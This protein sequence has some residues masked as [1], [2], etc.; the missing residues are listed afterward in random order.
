MFVWFGLNIRHIFLLSQFL[1]ITVIT[2]FRWFLI[3]KW[4]YILLFS[5]QGSYFAC[6]RYLLATFIS[7]LFQVLFVNTF[8]RNIF[9]FKICQIVAN[10]LFFS[11]IYNTIFDLICQ[12]F[13]I[14]SHSTMEIN[15]L[16][17]KT[18][19]FNFINSFVKTL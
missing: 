2:F 6:R 3:C 10:F 19:L 17:F 16:M 15:Y 4:L 11:L 5:F 14:F 1:E 9:T 12:H 13:L 18:N 8:F 7:I